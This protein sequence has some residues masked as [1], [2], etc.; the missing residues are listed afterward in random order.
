MRCSLFTRNAARHKEAA[1]ETN[2]ASSMTSAA[3]A[4]G[5]RAFESALEDKMYVQSVLYGV[6]DTS[7]TSL[8]TNTRLN[9]K[10]AHTANT[11][12]I[13]GCDKMKASALTDTTWCA[14]K[15]VGQLFRQWP[16]ITRAMIGMENSKRR[17]YGIC[18]EGKV[19]PLST[20]RNGK[21]RNIASN[22]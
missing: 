2:E 9:N 4:S 10:Q 14:N 21:L 13:M 22:F 7:L 20:G 19:V 17:E 6:P 8:L 15:Y 1:S 16:C 18:K 11:M 3:T 12:N 5:V